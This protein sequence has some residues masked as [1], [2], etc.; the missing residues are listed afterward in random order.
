MKIL[1]IQTAFIGDVILATPVLLALKRQHP[2]AEI[3]V[4]VR[5]GNESLLTNFPGLNQVI[6]WDKKRDKTRNLLGLI[7][8]IRGRR[9]DTVI[10]LQRFGATGLLTALSGAP[11]RIGF[12]KNPFSLFFTRK[13]QHAIASASL[14]ETQRNLQ[15]LSNT[16]ETTP[17]RPQLFPSASDVEKVKPL[18]SHPYYCIAPTSVWFTKQVPAE[19]WLELIRHIRTRHSDA[20]IYLLGGP[21]DG[22]ASEAI[23]SKSGDSLVENLCGK[24]SFLQTAALMQNADW[25]FVNDSAPLHIAS[26]MNA[27]VTAYFCSTTPDFGFG[28]LSDKSKTVQVNGLACRPCGLHGYKKCPK[29]HF[30]CALHLDMPTGMP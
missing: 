29:G 2:Q 30:Q 27:P 12:D 6:T 15:L 11:Q 28:P 18:Q 7:K 16:P 10:N 1:V 26:A 13:V 9:Y 17:T 8:E 4:L 24:L 19:K 23:R 20:K 22:M 14:H 21:D 25:N 3:D 5:K